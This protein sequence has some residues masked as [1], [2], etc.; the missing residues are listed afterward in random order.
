MKIAVVTGA[1]GFLGRSLVDYLC[2][3]G[4]TVYCIDIVIKNEAYENEKNKIFI[5]CDLKDIDSVELDVVPDLFYHLAWEG[6]STEKKNDVY[7][8]MRNLDY[9]LNC[10]KYA[11]K[12]GAKKFIFLGSA[13]EY[14]YSE[15]PI[16]GFSVVPAPCD[17]YSAMKASVHINL[18]LMSHQLEMSYVHIL[19]PSIYGEKRNDANIIT[20]TIKSLLGGER[21]T[22]TALEQ[23]WEY[24]YVDDAI[25]ALA[26]IGEKGQNGKSYPVGWNKQVPLAEYIFAVRDSIDP[27]LEMGVGERPYKTGRIDNCIMDTTQ[28]LA[29]TQF[30]PSVPFEE[31]IKATIDYIKNQG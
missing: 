19:L 16:D 14:A 9:S 18:E 6:V 5:K 23:I 10:L 31:G 29:D 15:K 2:R 22:F 26:V 8:Q 4:Y 25:K 24:V 20:Y 27:T 11:K 1:G 28:T 17:A 13:S 12:I 30:Q 7:V 21:P 3:D